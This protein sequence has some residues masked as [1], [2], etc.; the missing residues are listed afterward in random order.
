MRKLR[1]SVLRDLNWLLNATNLEILEDLSRYPQVRSSVINF[2]IATVTGR[3]ATS[4]DPQQA[5]RSIQDAI[6][7]FEPRLR[8]VSV[9]PE[10]S[11]ER[12]DRRTL[13]FKIDAELWGR[14]LPQRLLLRTRLD[15]E[16]GDLSVT[17][18]GTT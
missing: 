15:A 18:A 8:H 12:M 10:L 16:S 7:A 3:A 4:V 5:A 17:D 9:T 2:G 13:S 6:R 11:E 1:E 14:P